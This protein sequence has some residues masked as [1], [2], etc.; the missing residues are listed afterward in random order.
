MDII[1]ERI[2][3]TGG[4]GFLG[5]HL[6]RQLRERGCR[7]ENITVPSRD[8]YDLVHEEAVAR[9]FDGVVHPGADDG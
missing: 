8:D 7:P 4:D 6:C 9:F 2:V 1:E 5:G 3:V